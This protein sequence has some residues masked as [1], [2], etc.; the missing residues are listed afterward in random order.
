MREI[1]FRAWDSEANIMIYSDHRT[2][3]L[4]DVYYGFEMNG[5]GE[6][7]CRWE[8]DFTESQV[9]DGG[10]LDNIMQSTGL[11]DKNGVEIY[12]ADVV[13][14]SDGGSEEDSYTSVVKNYANE[15]YPAFDIEA[16]SS[17]RYESNI[18]AAIIGGD[19]ETI[20][21]IGN[22]YENSDLLEAAD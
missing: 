21:I 3:K 17:W 13:K 16:P 22:I 1:K 11:Q 15:G 9:L 14:V 20:E 12:E 10:I 6:L 4:Y 18:L 19:Y 2:R 8:G 5:K 7:E